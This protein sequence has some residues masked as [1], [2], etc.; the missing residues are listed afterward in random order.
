MSR[1]KPI[2]PLKRPLIARADPQQPICWPLLV[3]FA[4]LMLVMVPVV[5]LMTWGQYRADLRAWEAGR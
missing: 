3:I 5:V 4:P 2:H 1:P